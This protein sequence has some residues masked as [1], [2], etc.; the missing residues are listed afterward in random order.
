MNKEQKDSLNDFWAKHSGGKP[1]PTKSTATKEDIES[2][3]IEALKIQ[4][5]GGKTV[6]ENAGE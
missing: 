1:K 4:F 5:G 3:V 6:E 2:L